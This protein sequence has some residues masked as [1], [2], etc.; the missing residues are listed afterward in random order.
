[1]TEKVKLEQPP[2]ILIRWSDDDH[3]WIA[4]AV[5]A[6]NVQVVQGTSAEGGSPS[7]ALDALMDMAFCL[8]RQYFGVGM[9]QSDEGKVA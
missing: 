9:I 4:T 7:G 8:S 6:E 1:M 3:M 2:A 5:Q